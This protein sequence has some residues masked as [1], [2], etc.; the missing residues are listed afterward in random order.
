MLDNSAVLIM[1]FCLLN[2]ESLDIVLLC[3]CKLMYIF[4]IFSLLYAFNKAVMVLGAV[5][6]NTFPVSQNKKKCLDFIC[7]CVWDTVNLCRVTSI[8]LF[9]T[10]N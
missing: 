10:R 5:K 6:E 7:F 1:F 2:V 8:G 3:G 9:F 4:E